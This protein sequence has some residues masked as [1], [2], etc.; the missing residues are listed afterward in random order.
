M[1]PYSHTT[2]GTLK[3]QLAA[4]LSDRNDIFWIPDELELYLLEALR[5]FGALTGFW[6]ASASF[7]TVASQVFYDITSVN[8]AFTAILGYTITDTDLVKSIQYHFLEPAPGNSWSGTGM[9]DLSDVTRA[10][11]QRRDQFLAETGVVVTRSTPSAGGTPSSRIALDDGIIDLRRVAWSRDSDSEVFHLWREDEHSIS[12]FDQSWLTAANPPIAYSVSATPPITLQL[13]PPASVAGT[14]DLLSVDAGAALDPSAG[15]VLGIPDDLTWAV[16]WGAMA[17]LLGHE[18]EARDPRAAFCEQ[19]FRAGVEVAKAMATIVHAD[20]ADTPFLVDSLANLDAFRANWQN[21]AEVA[22]PDVIVAA[23]H[24]LVA[25]S[26]PPSGVVTVTLDVVR[27]ADVPT[28]PGDNVEIGREDLGGILDYAEHLAAFKMGGAEWDLTTR[29]A[30][31]FM[32]HAVLRNQLM[33]AGTRG[34][35]ANMFSLSRREEADRPRKVV[36][37]A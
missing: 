15:V 2:L 26:A 16:K 19:R 23:S 11:Q 10:L 32:T 35:L 4:R 33:E 5:M 17:D 24:N 22:T 34:S 8:A 13:M 28:G 31:E 27:R 12:A 36:A 3:T 6:R 9:F 21:D 30:E 18:G 25:V 1:S 29:Q 7:S 14:L 20:I 37:D